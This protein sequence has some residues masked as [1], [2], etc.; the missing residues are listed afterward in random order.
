MITSRLIR[1]VKL[2]NKFKKPE[3]DAFVVVLL[4]P[5]IAVRLLCNSQ[6]I[7]ICISKK[8]KRLE[9]II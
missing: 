4:N 9:M 6:S 3:K 5:I 2:K 1:Q 8:W 7:G